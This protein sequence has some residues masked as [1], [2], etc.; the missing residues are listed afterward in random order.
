MQSLFVKIFLWF[1]LS[2]VVV[3][4]TLVVSAGVIRSRSQDEERWNQLYHYLVQ[5]R[6]KRTADLADREGKLAALA[7]ADSLEKLD[8][9]NYLA[10]RKSVRDYLLDQRG[11]EVLGQ[12]IS[13]EITRI[14]PL[15]NQ[16]PVGEPHFFR[17]ERLAADKI[18]EPS[19]KIYT[20]VLPIPELPV[21]RQIDIFISKDIGKVGIIYLVSVLIVAGIFCYWLARNI[22]NPIDSLRLAATGIANEHL[23]VRVNE[24]VLKRR[25]ELAQ[26]GRDFNRMAE[27]ID[28]LV[29]AQRRLLADVSHQLRSPLTRLNL[30]LGLARDQ[31]SFAT[32]EHLDRIEHETDR[33]N[34]LI[35]QL[36]TLAR[37]ESGVDLEQEK[38]FDLGVLVQEV[39]SDGEYEAKSRNCGVKFTSSS[40]CPVE[41]AFEM[42][43][44]AVENVVRNAIRY[45]AAGTNVEISIHHVDAGSDSKAVIEVRD[46]GCGIPENELTHLF[47]PFHRGS[48]EHSNNSDGAGLGLAIAERAFRLH[49]GK[50]TATNASD[51]GLI[52]TLELLML[53]PSRAGASAGVSVGS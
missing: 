13:P 11:Q 36:L 7:Y 43:R 44:G 49:G 42:L 48:N 6:G 51:G 32:I 28:A 40:D 5:V 22:T 20:F 18:A 1:W 9:G 45:T 19:G 34:K 47:I 35:G 14:F 8:A 29:T 23:G 24:S 12:Q 16:Y 37:V 21:L 31:V 4:G 26:L 30:A 10:G 33:L 46:H 27:R 52:V 39:A 3:I 25:D 38:I 2:I 41:G 50:V 53:S 17:Q 15:M